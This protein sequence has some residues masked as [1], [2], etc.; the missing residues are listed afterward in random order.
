VATAAGSARRD[1]DRGMGSRRGPNRPGRGDP[2]ADWPID[3]P[4]SGAGDEG[5]AALPPGS[6]RIRPRRRPEG[7]GAGAADRRRCPP[8]DRAGGTGLSR[9]VARPRQRGRDDA[10]PACRRSTDRLGKRAGGAAVPPRPDRGAAV[11]RAGPGGDGVFVVSRAVRTDNRS[12]IGARRRDPL[13]G[14]AGCGRR[15]RV[16]ARWL[17]SNTPCSCTSLSRCR[18]NALAPCWWWV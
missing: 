18:S 12:A 16:R 6:R 8:V 13:S 14:T 4:G 1:L 9:R 11:L 10:G 3:E 17:G 7:G 2:R 5:A 15:R